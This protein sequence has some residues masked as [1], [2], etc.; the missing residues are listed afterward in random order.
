MPVV[1]ECTAERGAAGAV[2]G[3]CLGHNIW[4]VRP[5]QQTLQYHTPMSH[6]N[7]TLRWKFELPVVLQNA[8][9]VSLHGWAVGRCVVLRVVS[10]LVNANQSLWLV[11]GWAGWCCP[12]DA[13][14][15]PMAVLLR[16]S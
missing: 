11:F 5:R 12:A 15:E 13:L 4:R 8:W 2:S 10:I 14:L 6:S 7:V 9:H 1:A 16:R 3:V